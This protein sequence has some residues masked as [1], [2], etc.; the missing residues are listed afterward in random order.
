MSADVVVVGGS[1]GGFEAVCEL[2]RKLPGE[3]S[4]PIVVALH[5]S[6]KSPPGA[7]ETMIRECTRAL[8]VAVEDKEPLRAGCVYL[9][10][11]DY[12]L[13]V[14]D[15]SLALS[16]DDLV[17][18]SRPSID[19]LFE[20]AAD[21]YG[22]GVIGVLLSGA[23]PDGAAGIRR[24]K[25]RGGTTM[26]QDPATAVRPEMPRAAIGTG[27]VDLVA[28]IDGL[29]ARLGELVGLSSPGARQ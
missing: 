5:R 13:L 21:E 27:L 28:D 6:P 14:E 17:Q 10:P 16:T 15:G 2:L 24:I 20:S 25:Q 9:A 11:A 26:A 12:H 1:W 19:V 7:L 29:A 22:S 18:Y 4:T 8:V 3:P 23:N